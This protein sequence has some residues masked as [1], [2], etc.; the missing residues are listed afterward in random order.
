LVVESTTRLGLMSPTTAALIL[1][2]FT[3]TLLAVAGHRQLKLVG[4]LAVFAAAATAMVLIGATNGSPFW[5]AA[6]LVAVFATTLVLADG[7]G[8]PGPRWVAALVTDGVVMRGL[9]SATNQP[10]TADRVGPALLLCALVVALTLAFAGRRAFLAFSAAAPAGLGVSSKPAPSL[11]AFEWVQV[12][13]AIAL[14][15]G[16]A[17]RARDLL[18]W[19]PPLAAGLAL[20]VGAGSVTAGRKL[21]ERSE[22]AGA[23]W[24]H[25]AAGLELLLG[26]G[27]ILTTGASLGSVWAALAVGVAFLGRRFHPTTLWT[28]AVALGWA[29]S[30]SGGLFGLA[31][32]GLWA[33]PEAPLEWPATGVWVVSTLL[34]VTYLEMA[35]H[36]PT[37]KRGIGAIRAALLVLLWL[38]TVSALALAART[39]AGDDDGMLALGRTLLL[40]LSAI[41]LAL[42][43][44]SGAPA[45]TGW[46]AWGALG[47]AGIK[48]LVQDLELGRPSTLFLAFLALGGGVLVLPRLVL[49]APRPAKG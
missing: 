21:S 5:F 24:F 11:G 25:A 34:F 36:S 28:M 1:G 23:V 35:F 33:K 6:A 26:G 13:L 27:V 44:R 15:L 4:W 48:M 42:A 10:E 29:A 22:A 7:F 8:W 9:V 14:G 46:I 40:V 49:K 30:I 31:R 37:G 19:V 18:P 16:A 41:V 39:L 12:G 17:G 47:A 20:V 3:V 45:E 2:A 38:A 32:L 43:S